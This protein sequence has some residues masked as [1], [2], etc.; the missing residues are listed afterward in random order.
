MFQTNAYHSRGYMLATTSHAWRH[1]NS[2][3]L[4]H[5]V[6][7]CCWLFSI[8]LTIHVTEFPC[9]IR[10]SVMDTCCR[11]FLHNFHTGLKTIVC[12]FGVH[13]YRIELKGNYIIA[14]NGIINFIM[15]L[16]ETKKIGNSIENYMRS[17]TKRIFFFN[18]K[19]WM[20]KIDEKNGTTL[21]RLTSIINSH[22]Y[23]LHTCD[24]KTNPFPNIPDWTE[25]KHMAVNLLH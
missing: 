18:Q 23:L 25:F 8:W 11:F 9:N 12:F 16:F 6:R 7:H 24:R 21:W 4:F 3:K 15:L 22:G 13:R 1:N 10:K 17:K 19:W 14:Q 20:K 5:F 2:S